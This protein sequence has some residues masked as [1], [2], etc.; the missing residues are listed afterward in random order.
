MSDFCVLLM[1]HTS[2]TLIMPTQLTISVVFFIVWLLYVTHCFTLSKI[3]N[4]ATHYTVSN[5]EGCC[6]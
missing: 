6:S 2:S 5:N 1:P 4:V 3:L